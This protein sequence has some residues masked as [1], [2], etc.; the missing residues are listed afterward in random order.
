VAHRG[1]R[2]F[3]GGVAGDEHHR[4][5]G[6]A[7]GEPALELQPAHARQ[8]QIC[9][10]AAL[11]LRVEGGREFLRGREPAGFDAGRGEQHPKELPHML[12]VVDDEHRRHS[13]H[14]AG[15]PPWRT[16]LVVR[17]QL[18]VTSRTVMLTVG[19]LSEQRRPAMGV[20]PE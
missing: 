14:G 1:G 17:A 20:F 11:V 2:R 19:G 9:E 6:S 4:Q 12:V 10:H 8:L 18:A 13:C 3:D 15:Q 7:R 5:L 16:E